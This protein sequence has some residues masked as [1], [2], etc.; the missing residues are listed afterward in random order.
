MKIIE[1]EE[2]NQYIT[3]FVDG[4]RNSDKL[5][6]V[7][8][9]IKEMCNQRNVFFKIYRI[10]GNVN[11]NDIK[12]YE[13]KIKNY[14]NSLENFNILVED[15][16]SKF[17]QNILSAIG[18]FRELD[19]LINVLP[20]MADYFLETTIISSESN[21]MNILSKD[22]EQI[23]EGP[24][25]YIEKEFSDIVF[26]FFDSDDFL[27]CFNKEKYDEQEVIDKIKKS[28]LM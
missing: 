14:L 20:F 12:E 7:V 8:N 17:P 24:G 19:D 2:T 10:D 3:L 1:Y 21:Y 5:P 4:V 25:Y 22:K 16:H 13:N 6:K 18:Q 11:S 9:L 26:A 28:L 23:M 15:R 27:V